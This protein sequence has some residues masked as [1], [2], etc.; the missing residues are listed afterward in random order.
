MPGT[1]VAGTVEDPFG[2]LKYVA[3]KGDYVGWAAV[4]PGD[5]NQIDSKVQAVLTGK[6]SSKQVGEQLDALV[7]KLRAGS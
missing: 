5:L 6:S 3:D 2:L 7:K 4:T 1:K